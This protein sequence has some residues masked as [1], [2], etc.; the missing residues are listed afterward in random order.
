M[1]F[2]LILPTICF[3]W[4]LL[5]PPSF[6]MGEANPL[7]QRLQSD[8]VRFDLIEDS[9]GVSISCDH[10]L[11]PHIPWWRVDC[12]ERSFTVDAWLERIGPN[13]SGETKISLMFHASEGRQSSGEKI[14]QF[15]SHFTSITLADDTPINEIDS[16][17]DVRNGLA[18]LRLKAII[19]RPGAFNERP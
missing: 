9:T 18:S 2:G 17:L 3:F 14:T 5:T 12:G 10:Q 7:R 4:S 8:Q 15:K 1:H 11:L 16:W 13:Q 19:S 6:G